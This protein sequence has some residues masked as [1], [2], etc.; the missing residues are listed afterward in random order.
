MVPFC[1][2]SSCPWRRR[3][4]WSPC[5]RTRQKLAGWLFACL[6]CSGH[7]L[8]P[9]IWLAESGPLSCLLLFSVNFLRSL[10]IFWSSGLRWGRTLCRWS[11]TR[12]RRTGGSPT[13]SVSLLDIRLSIKWTTKYEWD[14]FFHNFHERPTFTVLSDYFQTSAES[15]GTGRAVA[16]IPRV[17]GGGTHRLTLMN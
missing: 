12:W 14:A 17:R 2:Q 4:P 13:V 1:R 8:L 5:T 11:T 15:W 9:T 3:G 6:L 7:F 10:N 16:R